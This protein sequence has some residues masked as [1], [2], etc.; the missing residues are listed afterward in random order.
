MKTKLFIACI[1]LLGACTPNIK[2]DVKQI[3]ETD[4]TPQW[5][6]HIDRPE[7]SS[8]NAEV[9]QSCEIFNQ[10]INSFLNEFRDSLKVQARRYIAEMD[11]LGETPV[12]PFQLYVQDS[13]FTVDAKMLSV[14]LAVYTLEGG[15]NG[16][17]NFYALNYDVKKQTFLNNQD[18]LPTAKTADINALLKANLKNPDRCFD[19][20]PT[21]ENYTCLNV[22][23][24]HLIF[25]Y[26]PF[27]LGPHAC[28]FATIDI[29]KDKL[30]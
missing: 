29:A 30:K 1:L 24:T 18:L 4:D 5:E 28:G 8:A 7:F 15:A 3:Q 11:S 16:I 21:V 20:E 25:T 26:D 6:I 14:R 9:N 17:T 10:K 12:G 27:I 13:I 23:P 22:T 19:T 2:V